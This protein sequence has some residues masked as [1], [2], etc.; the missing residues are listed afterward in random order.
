MIMKSYVI[1][2][3][4]CWTAIHFNVLNQIMNFFF[5][6][7][8]FLLQRQL[9][10]V[11]KRVIAKIPTKSIK[12]EDNNDIDNDCCAICIEPYK[13]TDIIRVL[14]C[15]YEQC[16]I[17]FPNNLLYSTTVFQLIYFFP[18]CTSDTNFTRAASIHGCL[19]IAHVQCVKWIF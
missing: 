3:W 18:I 17:W 2:S 10:T 4:V 8:I 1:R 5:F 16:S 6:L 12:S 7:N 9:C 13:I 19:S 14:P 11:A 15:R